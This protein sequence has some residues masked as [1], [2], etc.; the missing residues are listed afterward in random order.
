MKYVI[1]IGFMCRDITAGIYREDGAWVGES[2]ER[3]EPILNEDGEEEYDPED[4][5]EACFRAV[6]SVH[7]QYGIPAE[8]IACISISCHNSELVLLG[9]DGKPVCPSRSGRDVA[10]P[11]EDAFL[12]DLEYL[13]QW[14]GNGLIHENLAAKLLWMRKR[15][16]EKLAKAK[17]LL[18]P[19]DFLA[20]R[21]TGVLATDV[22]IASYTQ[23]F[24]V[25]ER[26]WSL[27]MLGFLGLS[28]SLLPE[29]RESRDVIGALTKE[30]CEK[31][32]LTEKTLVNAG[33]TNK[34]C[35]ELG[36]LAVENG[37]DMVTLN[38]FGDVIVHSEK[39]YSGSDG[40]I[41]T[42]C[43]G[44]PGSYMLIADNRLAVAPAVHGR[45]PDDLPEAE[46]LALGEM[47]RKRVERLHSEAR[48]PYGNLYFRTGGDPELWIGMMA[49]LT[50]RRAHVIERN[51][52]AIAGCAVSA[53]VSAGLYA[54]ER[55]A[56][57]AM[58]RPKAV[59][60]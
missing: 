19:K 41:F 22:T 31:T 1:G 37:D 17:T 25:A 2:K 42:C 49:K 3:I 5:A 13:R 43:S 48:V 54:S 14:T 33:M 57:Q 16:P 46:R 56:A 52:G 35:I 10:Y 28:P 44:I 60:E 50:G 47:T 11:E 45:L 29:V 26:K 20:Y 39:P 6:R 8:D 24:H 7:E 36:S 40:C 51:N 15:E 4:W 38:V 21:L 27:P 32:G 23:L 55:E 34:A 12:R 30:A 53:C 59:F 9:E 18:Y 58:I